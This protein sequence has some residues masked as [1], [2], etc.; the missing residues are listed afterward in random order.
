M[1]KIIIDY[2]LLHQMNTFSPKIF[3][4]YAW[5][6]KCH[7]DNFSEF[8]KLA[9]MALF[10]PCM[11]IKNFFGQMYSFDVVNKSPLLFFS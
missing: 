8:S 9:K 6:K 4:F 3:D 10:Y 5:V 7:F 2:C 1:K 11:K